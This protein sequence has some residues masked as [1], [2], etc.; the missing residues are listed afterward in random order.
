[1]K[2]TFLSRVV[3]SDYSSLIKENSPE[4]MSQMEIA[5][6]TYN[7]YIEGMRKVIEGGEGTAVPTS[8]AP[9]TWTPSP[10]RYAAR[11]VLLSTPPAALTMARSS[12]SPPWKTRRSP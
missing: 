12:A 2:A 8:A 5:S 9:R 11:P 3:A 7:T 10:S 6:T 4:I 1:M